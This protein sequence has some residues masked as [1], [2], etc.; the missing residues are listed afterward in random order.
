[1]CLEAVHQVVE[2]GEALQR[3]LESEVW[4]DDADSFFVRNS[5]LGGDGDRGDEVRWSQEE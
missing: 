3:D 1:M 4:G 2:P 5:P